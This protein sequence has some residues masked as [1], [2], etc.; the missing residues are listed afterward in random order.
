METKQLAD[1]LNVIV[2][3]LAP[4]YCISILHF[5]LARE[6]SWP[7]IKLCSMLQRHKQQVKCVF[8]IS[9]WVKQGIDSSYFL[10]SSLFTC[11]NT[12]TQTKMAWL[13][14]VSNLFVQLLMFRVIFPQNISWKMCF[15]CVCVS[16]LIQMLFLYHL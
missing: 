8:F 1:V 3:M 5:Q 10:S 16:F 13:S 4:K 7:V 9:Y 6:N 15:L 14:P 11:T 12:N 2:P